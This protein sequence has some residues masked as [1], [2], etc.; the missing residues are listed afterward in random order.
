V[1]ESVTEVSQ[2]SFERKLTGGRGVKWRGF[3]AILG[4][5]GSSVVVDMGCRGQR[6][7]I[8][9]FLAYEECSSQVARWPIFG[10]CGSA[11]NQC[12]PQSE[13]ILGTVGDDPQHPAFEIVKRT[14][15]KKPSRSF[16]FLA[17]PM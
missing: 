3:G 5:G 15:S 1:E 17:S 11:W 7:L 8:G 2:I 10:N 9:E 14:A 16:D 12:M 13:S 6:E 4:F